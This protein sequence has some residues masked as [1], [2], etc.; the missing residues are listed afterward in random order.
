MNIMHCDYGCPNHFTHF[1]TS[2]LKKFKANAN[3]RSIEHRALLG[4]TTRILIK[5]ILKKKKKY[6]NL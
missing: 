3:T 1:E 4:A 5:A 6:Q 2:F